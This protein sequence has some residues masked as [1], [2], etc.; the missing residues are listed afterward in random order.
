MKRIFFILTLFIT[1]CTS[2]NLSAK[3]RIAFYYNTHPPTYLFHLYHTVIVQPY[4]KL[5][6]KQIT[7]KHATNLLAYVSLGE[8]HTNS[9]VSKLIQPSWVLIKNHTWHTL[10]MDASNPEWQQFFIHKIVSPLLKS[11]YSGIFLDTADSYMLSAKTSQAQQRQEAGLISIIN[12]IHTSFPKAKI[13]INRGFPLL[14]AIHQ[15]ISGVVAE[16]LY[17]GW[18]QQKKTYVTIPDIANNYLIKELMTVKNKYH[19]PVIV[20]SYLPASQKKDY[21]AVANKIAKLGFIPWITNHSLTTIGVNT[22]QIEPRRVM[23]IYFDSSGEDPYGET[24]AVFQKLAMPLEQLGYVPILHNA[25]APFTDNDYE[26]DFAGIVFYVDDDPTKFPLTCLNWLL[27][28]KKRGVPVLFFNDFPFTNHANFQK[29]FDISTI[30]DT[31]KLGQLT[32]S[33]EQAHVGFETPPTINAIAPSILVHHVHKAWLSLRSSTGLTIPVIGTTSWGGFVLLHYGYWQSDNKTTRWIVNPFMALRHMLKLK[34]IPIPDT[35]TENGTRLMMAEID[36]DGFVNRPEFDP[37]VFA[38]K[39]IEDDILN[40]YKM[41]TTVSVV[42]GEIGPTGIYPNESKAA[43]VV[44]RDIFKPD[45]IEL[46][47]HSY[48]HPF[49]WRV[50]EGYAKTSIHDTIHLPIKNY[51]FNLKREIKGSVN[52]INHTLAPPNKQVKV[53]LWTGNA[54]PSEKAVKM[55]YSIGLSNMNGGMTSI[56]KKQPSL[57]NV[58]PLGIYKGRYYQVYAPIGN[59]IYYTNNWSGPYYG[60]K[61]VIQTLKMT[62]SPRRLK[63]V[64]IYYHFY[65]GDKLAGLQALKTI[66]NWTQTQHL[67]HIFVSSYTHKVLDFNNAVLQQIDNGWLIHTNGHLREFRIP[68]SA[69]YPDFKRSKNIIGYDDFQKTRYIHL[70]PSHESHL[71][72]SLTKPTEPYLISANE[73]VLAWH[74]DTDKKTINMTLTGFDPLQLQLGNMLNCTTAIDNQRAQLQKTAITTITTLQAGKHHIEIKCGT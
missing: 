35:T 8:V 62:N 3:E 42:E 43:E 60:F 71:I 27:E 25:L 33:K 30:Q 39:V 19:L 10:V 73:R 23:F 1:T 40:H 44:A 63:P 36:G 59:E 37:S 17:Q 67:M 49:D 12:K 26:Q 52:Y 70:G 41:P 47:T 28:E 2:I 66:Y 74:K 22:S 50:A 56:S 24:S 58:S 34:H 29:A 61:N 32:F 20:I 9:K 57:M 16:S 11:G 54:D 15:S 31:S 13:L 64:D 53:F 55:T 21:L 51:R 4:A 14:P 46:A 45:Y 68:P 72:L 65:S 48:S 5:N 38:A 69:G 7:K 18:D 6:P